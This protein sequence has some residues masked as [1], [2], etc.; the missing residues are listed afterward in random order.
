MERMI[1]FHE[2]CHKLCLLSF[3]IVLY[4]LVKFPGKPVNGTDVVLVKMYIESVIS[5]TGFFLIWLL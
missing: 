5:F 4:G 1:L 3:N 2:K